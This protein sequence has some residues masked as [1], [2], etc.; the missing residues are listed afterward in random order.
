MRTLVL[1]LTVAGA[2]VARAQPSGRC[3]PV[4]GDS[5]PTALNIRSLAGLY[6]LEWHPAPGPWRRDVRHERLWLWRTSPSDSSITSPGVRPAPNDTLRYPLF[7]AIAARNSTLGTGDAL[8]RSTDP[9]IPPVLLFV[10]R[11][12]DPSHRTRPWLVLFVETGETR[13]PGIEHLDGSGIGVH[14]DHL[15]PEGFAGSYG[16]WGIVGTDSGYVC[17]RR[18]P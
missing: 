17:A 6:E 7:G 9:I 8:R 13:E 18:V 2:T 16:P 12:I 4:V 11:P 10:G 1:L 15:W 3:G 14:L 5:F